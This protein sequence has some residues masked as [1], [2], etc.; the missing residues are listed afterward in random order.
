MLYDSDGCALA[1]GVREFEPHSGVALPDGA[2]VRE[3]AERLEADG[4]WD[5]P[6]YASVKARDPDGH[7]VEF[8]WEPT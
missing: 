1:L 3:L 4:V 2:A 5:G 8:W 7:V 6:E